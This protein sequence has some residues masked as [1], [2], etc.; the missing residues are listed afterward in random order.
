MDKVHLQRH[1][2]KT[3]FAIAAAAVNYNE[4]PLQVVARQ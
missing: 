4:K 2:E 3:G 1:K